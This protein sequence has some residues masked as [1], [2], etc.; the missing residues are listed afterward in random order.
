VPPANDP[1]VQTLTTRQRF[2]QHV[3]NPECASCH[4]RIDGIGFGFEQFDGIGAYRW[5]DNGQWVD[6]RGTVI[7]TGEI[8]GDFR[9]AAELVNRLSGSRLLAACFA[10]QAYRYA[11][12]QVESAQDDLSWLTDASSTDAKMTAI[13][14]AIVES[15]IF[16]TRTFE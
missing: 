8:D 7:G 3:S 6:D 2:E 12:G 11:M 13:L 10:R 15:P 5:M 16:V 1:S 9:G 4:T 14:L